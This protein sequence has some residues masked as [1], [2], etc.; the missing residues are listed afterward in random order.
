MIFH[1]QFPEKTI[2]LVSVQPKYGQSQV[3]WNQEV[4]LN[5]EDVTVSYA[6]ITSWFDPKT[7]KVA[8]NSSKFIFMYTNTCNNVSRLLP[9]SANCIFFIEIDI[10]SCVNK[11]KYQKACFTFIVHTIGI[12]VASQGGILYLHCDFDC[13]LITYKL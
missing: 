10:L 3:L 6:D 8:Y 5:E 11:L 7:G 13:C 4:C 1:F 12:H 2:A 9:C